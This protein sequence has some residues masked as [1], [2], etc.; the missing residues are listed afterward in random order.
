ME[1]MFA[2]TRLKFLSAM[3]PPSVPTRAFSLSPVSF[4]RPDAVFHHP[5][6]E[7]CS[8]STEPRYKRFNNRRRKRVY[9]GPKAGSQFR[10]CNQ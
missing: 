8:F 4:S 6:R 2:V 10:A 1:E 5:L 3:I 9:T 7:R